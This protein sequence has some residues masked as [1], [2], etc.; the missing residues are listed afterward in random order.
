MDSK[1]AIREL[2]ILKED[3]WDDD[4]YGHETEQYDDTMLAIDMAIEALKN[5]EAEKEHIIK[6]LEEATVIGADCFG[7]GFECIPTWKAIEIVKRGE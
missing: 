1:E 2:E 4:G 3:Y 7:E 5:Q 6:E